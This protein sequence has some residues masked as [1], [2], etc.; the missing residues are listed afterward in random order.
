[1]KI[2]IKK[3]VKRRLNFL[4]DNASIIK[5]QINYKIRAQKRAH[6]TITNLLSNPATFTF[7]SSRTSEPE[8]LINI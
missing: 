5:L 2:N 1:M 7:W 3:I 6:F 4:E 8:E